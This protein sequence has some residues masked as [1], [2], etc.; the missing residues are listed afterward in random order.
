MTPGSPPLLSRE[1]LAQVRP[2][3]VLVNVARGGHVDEIALAEALGDG[4]VA[5]AALD[6]R[7]HEPPTEPDALRE[8]ANVILT[9]HIAASSRQAAEDLHRL[10]AAYVLG[11]LEDAG[12]IPVA[13]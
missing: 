8:L 6:V 13:V 10:A 9:P 3:V 1:A 7:A 11:L 12:R 4:R 2:G 5:V